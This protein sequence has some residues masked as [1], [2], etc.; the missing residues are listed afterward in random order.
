MASIVNDF[1]SP[2]LSNKKRE[3]ALQNVEK[4]ILGL[5]GKIENNEHPAR[6]AERWQIDRRE[7]R[8]KALQLVVS[9][10]KTCQD[11]DASRAE[12]IAR[13]LLAVQA[14]SLTFPVGQSEKTFFKKPRTNS[15]AEPLLEEGTVSC[16]CS[17]I[18]QVKGKEFESVCVV[19]PP[20]RSPENNTTST[21]LN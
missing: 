14:L 9:L 8:R 11:S 21:P 16:S 7:L 4:V 17:T 3:T 1:W 18:H 15:W 19:I 10:P 13:L 6:A 2:F 12:W 20:D 5:M